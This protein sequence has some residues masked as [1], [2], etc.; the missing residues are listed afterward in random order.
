[1]LAAGKRRMGETYFEMLDVDA[2]SNVIRF[3]SMRPL[4]GDWHNFVEA[5]DLL[6]LYEAGGALSA[7]G[8][9][10]FSGIGCA[11]HVDDDWCGPRREC[12]CLSEE[13]RPRTALLASEGRCGVAR[14]L[15]KAGDSFTQ[16]TCTRG[17]DVGSKCARA[18]AKYGENVKELRIRAIV[19]AECLEVIL[20]ARGGSLEMLEV[21]TR[22][23]RVA[24]VVVKH[25]EMLRELVLI[26]EHRSLTRILGAVGAGLSSLTIKPAL[27]RAHIEAIRD[28]CRNVQ[29]VHV[30]CEA[31]LYQ[32]LAE[33][34][35][36]FGRQLRFAPLHR[37]SCAQI[38][39][40]TR[41][42][43]QLSVQ[44]NIVQHHA[45]VLH[46]IG[47]HL[48]C[49]EI[50]CGADTKLD[51]VGDALGTCS[52]LQK[53]YVNITNGVEIPEVMGCAIFTAP[54]AELME[55]RF[56]PAVSVDAQLARS[57]AYCT[58][59]LRVLQISMDCQFA[60]MLA[61]G[62][63]LQENR[64][65]AKA[66]VL[67]TGC[68]EMDDAA[69]EQSAGASE[70]SS[71]DGERMFRDPDQLQV[72]MEYVQDFLCELIYVF[73]FAPALQELVV[74]SFPRV[75]ENWDYLYSVGEAC[76]RL[77]YRRIH[78]SILGVD[79]LPSEGANYLDDS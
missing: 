4:R 3:L 13:K 38:R 59:H 54:F 64:G 60:S 66:K 79:Y 77:R 11:R 12:A 44:I 67:L 57:I 10:T 69:S 39:L 53:L 40:V 1:M 6:A 14:V 41:H 76:I 49:A 32:A 65:L 5:D 26:D 25:C 24:E 17:R 18:L 58:R 20:G 15:A 22:A 51:G 7:G 47:A 68:E 19:T 62:A 2:I 29:T 72:P 21:N 50:V 55:L 43:T 37:F 73:S 71:D 74:T 78:A 75:N 31:A 61:L 52:N 28:H 70:W 27:T 8:R 33:M 23:P 63:I 30:W 56:S 46:A 35:V 34:Y 36:S 9:I 16:F 45:M 42:C 48:R